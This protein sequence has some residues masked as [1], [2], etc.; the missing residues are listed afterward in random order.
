MS[1]EQ[2][3]LQTNN[4]RIVKNTL[5]LYVR[6]LFG[7]IVSLYTSRIVLNTLGV[8]DYG[9]YNVVGGFVTMFSLISN[10]LSASTGRFLTFELGKGDMQRL[11]QVFSTSLIIHAILAVAVL[12]LAETIGIW[13][14]NERMTIPAVRLYAANWVFQAS[15]LAFVMGLFFIPYS[16]SIVSHE[17]MSVFAYLGIFDVILRLFIVLFIAY[18]PW[19]FDR[20]IVYALLLVGVSLIL[21]LVNMFYCSRHFKECKFQFAFH[22]SYWKEMSS[23]VRWNFIGCTAGLL[24]DQG[25]NL[26]LNLFM[27]PI[28]NAARGIALSVN[29][30]VSGFVGN[31]MVALN[32]QI[33]KSYAVGDYSYMMSL[34]ERG[35][36]FSFYI[37]FML[38]LPILFETELI[39]TL[40]LNDFPPHTVNFVRL[41]LLLSL[42]D[43]LSNTLITLQ[44]A[45]GKIRNYQI[46]VGGALMLN[47]PVSYLCLK[48]GCVPESVFVVAL[49]VS[50]LCL[51]LR[52]L[53]LRRMVQ[54]SVKQ[55]LYNV[56]LNVLSVSLIAALIPTLAYFQM[57]DG[58]GRFLSIIFFCVVCSS[59]SIYFIGC[60]FS[61]RKFILDRVRMVKKRIVR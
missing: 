50:V 53:F 41:M 31:F 26:L 18:A 11:K 37:L 47:F 59:L 52:L 2:D 38:T 24:K 30:A 20:L 55:Y 9:I 22:S 25:V 17:K 51:I 27:G 14:L 58:W 6:M 29:T 39:L 7:M 32:P 60:S 15:V 34:I 54:L 36:R 3:T 57:E 56:C 49:F 23:F 35:S 4:K 5:M 21:Q 8:E 61:E 12:L 13:F 10:S 43:V 44:S 33:T 46:A 16:A 1:T 28:V 19:R 40:W 48:M 42:S 45:T